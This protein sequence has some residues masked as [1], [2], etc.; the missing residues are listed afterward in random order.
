MGVGKKPI[1]SI[2]AAHVDRP[3]ELFNH[4]P[5]EGLVDPI[6][7]DLCAAKQWVES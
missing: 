6:T 7:L 2:L 4:F 5:Y 1:E 3:T